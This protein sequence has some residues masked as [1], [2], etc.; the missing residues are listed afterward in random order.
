MHRL[1]G[2]ARG[3]NKLLLRLGE[4]AICFNCRTNTDHVQLRMPSISM[5]LIDGDPSG[6]ETSSTSHLPL[7]LSS[8]ACCEEGLMPWRW[9]IVPG[10][11]WEINGHIAEK[12]LG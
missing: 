10:M 9:F 3:W 11:L 12:A 1:H 8:N 7:K 5:L 4:K 2:D 6:A